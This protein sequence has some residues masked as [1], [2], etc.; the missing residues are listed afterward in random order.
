MRATA[1]PTSLFDYDFSCDTE[2]QR[3]YASEAIADM[4]AYLSHNRRL[5]ALLAAPEPEASPEPLEAKP[6]WI[7]KLRRMQDRALIEDRME[8]YFRIVESLEA[9]G[10]PEIA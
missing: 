8:A 10:L 1:F 5:A 2:P 7:A 9:Y 4:E 3:D 6:R